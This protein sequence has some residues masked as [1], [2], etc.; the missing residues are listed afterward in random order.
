MLATQLT[1]AG[2][3]GIYGVETVEWMYK[4][5][6]KGLNEMGYYEDWMEGSP[7]K[8]M[9]ENM[10][11]WASM[12]IPSALTGKDYHSR[13]DQGTIHDPTFAG[14]FP[15]LSDLAEQAKDVITALMNPTQEK[16]DRALYSLTPSTF[17]GKVEMNLPTLTGAPGQ[18]DSFSVDRP[19]EP[20]YKRT[21]A[22]KDAR[23]TLLHGVHTIVE[24]RE[25]TGNFKRREAEQLKTRQIAIQ[26]DR[27]HEASREGNDKNKVAAIRQVARLD[28]PWESLLDGEIAQLE[29][30]ATTADEKNQLKATQDNASLQ[31]L[32]KVKR[33][34]ESTRKVRENH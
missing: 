11:T 5:F 8:W 28:S 10:P 26:T 22:D 33:Q 17:K 9:L 31:L 1:M 24:A 3:M 32:Q 34:L 20:L 13:L 27:F 29:K 16:V 21:Q 15:F 12:G 30:R 4:W 2:T 14:T 19:D 18:G 7:K 6:K 23:D 25:K